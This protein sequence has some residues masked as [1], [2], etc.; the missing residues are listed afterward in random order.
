MPKVKK[1]KGPSDYGRQGNISKYL[2]TFLLHYL[3]TWC[4]KMVF[5]IRLNLLK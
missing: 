1:E 5:V 3:A 4:L 2:K